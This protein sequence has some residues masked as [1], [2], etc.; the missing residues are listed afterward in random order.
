MIWWIRRNRNKKSKNNHHG[1]ITKMILSGSSSH[2]PTETSKLLLPD[3]YGGRHIINSYDPAS[4]HD[5]AM[6]MMELYPLQQQQQQAVPIETQSSGHHHHHPAIP[7][8]ELSAHIERLKSNNGQLF[9]NEY[10][11]I[12][13]GQQFTWEHVSGF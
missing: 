4:S 6:M 12:E 11:S 9:T 1:S 2:L 10:E 7:I 8:T 5:A 3:G 13:T